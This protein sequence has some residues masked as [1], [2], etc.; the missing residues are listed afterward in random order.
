MTGTERKRAWRERQKAAAA[1]VN[2]N[3]NKAPAPGE[4]GSIT[5][6]LADNLKTL[7]T[8]IRLKHSLAAD[9]EIAT[10]IPKARRICTQLVLSGH[11][12]PLD[13]VKKHLAGKV[14]A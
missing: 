10:V 3:G 7:R 2:G 5:R 4:P 9:A 14:R 8:E 13:L 1:A 6:E 11:S 12:A